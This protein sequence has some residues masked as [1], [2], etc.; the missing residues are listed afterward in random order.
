MK[1]S[2]FVLVVFIILFAAALPMFSDAGDNTLIRTGLEINADKSFTRYNCGIDVDL[3]LD[4]FLEFDKWSIKP[5]LGMLLL[6]ASFSLNS[7]DSFIN[8][9]AGALGGLYLGVNC[10]YDAEFIGSEGKAFL[11]AEKLLSPF[12]YY[13]WALKVG[14]RSDH[15]FGGIKLNLDS[16]FSGIGIFAKYYNFSTKPRSSFSAT[17]K[18]VELFVDIFNSAYEYSTTKDISAFNKIQ[19]GSFFYIVDAIDEIPNLRPE[20]IAGLVDVVNKKLQLPP[21][22]ITN[23]IR[24]GVSL[25]KDYYIN[26]KASSRKLSPQ[27]SMMFKENVANGFTQIWWKIYDSLLKSKKN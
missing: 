19:P 12:D 14:Y 6:P 7:G 13:S 24:S 20:E 5:Y 2:I 16:G 17:S 26:Y 9:L 10:E 11:S 18:I 27:E 22:E 23:L 3:M 15:I 1:K 4:N 8:G 21:S 25:L